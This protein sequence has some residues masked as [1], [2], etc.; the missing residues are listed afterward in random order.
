MGD[1]TM[2]IRQITSIKSICMIPAVMTNDRVEHDV[3]QLMCTRMD[4]YAFRFNPGNMCYICTLFLQIMRG[5]RVNRG[6]IIRY[7]QKQY[8]VLYIFTKVPRNDTT[9]YK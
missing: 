8:L 1:G 4:I 6:P 7:R 3:Y 2:H 9:V 5:T